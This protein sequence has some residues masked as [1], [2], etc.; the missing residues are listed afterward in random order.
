MRPDPEEHSGQFKLQI[1]VSSAPIARGIPFISGL[2]VTEPARY[3]YAARTRFDD[4]MK[5]LIIGIEKLRSK[6]RKYFP[7]QS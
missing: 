3:E 2:P 5:G 6:I 1:F 7:Q 4:L